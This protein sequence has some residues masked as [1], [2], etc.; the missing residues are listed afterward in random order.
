M[1]NLRVQL[2]LDQVQGFVPPKASPIVELYLQR[3][4]NNLTVLGNNLTSTA[5]N[6]YL[7]KRQNKWQ[8]FH[9]TI[10]PLLARNDIVLYPADKNMGPSYFISF[11]LRRSYITKERVLNIWEI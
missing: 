9:N 1:Y 10:K 5:Q 2:S 7:W 8:P 11:I 6:N 4:K 3:V